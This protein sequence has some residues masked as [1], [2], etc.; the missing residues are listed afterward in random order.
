[1]D[2]DGL[3]QKGLRTTH[4]HPATRLAPKWITLWTGTQYKLYSNFIKHLICISNISLD[5]TEILLYSNSL[6][7]YP[8]KWLQI[9]TT[10]VYLDIQSGPAV[11]T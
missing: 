11:H 3:Q 10:A 8:G 4:L 9:Y 7:I 2:S 6:R 5:N 1:M